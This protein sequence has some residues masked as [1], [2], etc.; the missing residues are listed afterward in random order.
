MILFFLPCDNIKNTYFH[1]QETVQQ[2]ILDQRT[3]NNGRLLKLQ[4]KNRQ[5]VFVFMSS[6]TNVNGVE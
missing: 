4:E 3:V 5:R 6:F 1:T 2:P